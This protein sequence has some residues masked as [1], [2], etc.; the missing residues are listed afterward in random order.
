MSELV[1]EV[2]AYRLRKWSLAIRMRDRICFMCNR[3]TWL[4]AHHIYPKAIYPDLALDLANGISLC[5]VCHIVVHGG[6]TFNLTNWD[7]FVPMF[8]KQTKSLLEWN[9][10]YQERI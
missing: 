10:N 8:D 9:T 7:K 5:K 3:A 2:S 4:E 6:D 1:D